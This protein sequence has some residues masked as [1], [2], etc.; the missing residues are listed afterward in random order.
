MIGGN[1]KKL[2]LSIAIAV[3]F[4]TAYGVPASL[5]QNQPSASGHWEGS[6][7]VHGNMV[8]I[9]VDLTLSDKG[10]WKGTIAIPVQSLRDYPL[11]NLKVEGTNVSFE[12]AIAPGLPTFKGKLSAD[13]KTLAGDLS[14]SGQTHP[15]KLERKGDAK[16]SAAETEAPSIKVSGD[17][18]GNWQGTLDAGGAMLRLI[19]KITKVADGSFT[20]SLDSPDQGS[21]NMPIKTLIATGDSL[22]FE[23]KYISASYEGKFNKERT[24]VSGSWHQGGPLP[25]TLKREAKK[26]PE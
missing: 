9:I 12:M 26:K 1:M 18:E 14:Q 5:A 16:I 8:E 20:A 7:E 21:N 24:E 10:S 25:L 23:L 22:T 19:L 3:A 11:S 13:G 4:F 6:I 17:V 15:F 2:F